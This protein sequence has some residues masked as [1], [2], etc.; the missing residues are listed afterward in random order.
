[1]ARADLTINLKVEG[2]LFFTCFDALKCALNE[3]ILWRRELALS[4]AFAACEASSSA[5]FAR[6]E[7]EQILR[8][9]YAAQP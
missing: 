9:G 2:A 8:G 1:M 4:A 6:V 3:P 7:I 5:R